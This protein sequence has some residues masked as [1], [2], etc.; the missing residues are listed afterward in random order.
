VRERRFVRETTELQE[1]SAL[2]QQQTATSDV[3]RVISSSPSSSIR[4]FRPSWRTVH[5]F[6]K[7][8]YRRQ[9]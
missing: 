9:L 4:Y 3:L 2:L 5:V 7:R 6:A 1:L 8:G